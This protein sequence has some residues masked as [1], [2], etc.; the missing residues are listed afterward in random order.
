MTP[1]YNYQSLNYI[2]RLAADV[3]T[4]FFYYKNTKNNLYK[5]KTTIT[6]QHSRK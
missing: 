3:I 1:K 6:S 4:L 2:Y 5:T